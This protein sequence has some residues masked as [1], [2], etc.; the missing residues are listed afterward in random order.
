MTEAVSA[1]FPIIL[2]FDGGRRRVELHKDRAEGSVV[3]DP[4]PDDFGL[5]FFEDFIIAFEDPTG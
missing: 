4:D 1:E 3:G 5:D 2:G